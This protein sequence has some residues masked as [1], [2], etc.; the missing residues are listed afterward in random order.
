MAEYEEFLI[1]DLKTG[2]FIGKEPWLSPEDGFPVLE[3]ARVDKGVLRKRRG[4]E[5]IIPTGFGGLPI[6]GMNTISYSGYL[7]V[8]ACTTRQAW[9]VHAETP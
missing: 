5:V 1:S 8:I 6:V 3:N 2:L 4:H 7:E 9:H